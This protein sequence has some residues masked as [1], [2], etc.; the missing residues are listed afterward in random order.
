[1]TKDAFLDLIQQAK[2]LEL[3][4]PCLRDDIVP[5]VFLPRPATWTTFRSELGTLLG[6]SA[7]DITVIGSGRLGFSAKPG[8][9]L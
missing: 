4:G 3:I 2:F 1:M 5:Y 7:T 6:V 9:N 8:N